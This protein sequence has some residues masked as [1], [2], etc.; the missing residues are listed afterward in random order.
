MICSTYPCYEDVG[1]SRTHWSG[2]ARSDDDRLENITI[3]YG[4]DLDTTDPT[5]DSGDTKK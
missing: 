2:C 1:D 3:V 4:S 5:D